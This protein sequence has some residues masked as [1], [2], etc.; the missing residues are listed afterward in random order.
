M[1]IKKRIESSQQTIN[2]EKHLG[3]GLEDG[4]RFHGSGGLV[5]QLAGRV[6]PGL[7]FGQ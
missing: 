6:T 7:D 2:T 1:A 5:V 3:P 4:Q